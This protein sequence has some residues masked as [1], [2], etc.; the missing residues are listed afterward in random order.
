[1]LR[2]QLK[3]LQCSKASPAQY[4]DDERLRRDVPQ[5]QTLIYS[6]YC[7]PIRH[8][9]SPPI[10]LAGYPDMARKSVGESCL[11]GVLARVCVRIKGLRTQ[12]SWSGGGTMYYHSLVHLLCSPRGMAHQYTRDSMAAERTIEEDSSY[13]PLQPN[14]L[15]CK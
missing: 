3:A 8:P 13:T 2:S 7:D 9:L 4:T 6:E 14:S 5:T 15:T 12:S 10:P 1:V 11:R